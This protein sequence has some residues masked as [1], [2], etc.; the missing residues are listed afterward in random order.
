LPARDA[1]GQRF[2]DSWQFSPCLRN[3]SVGAGGAPMGDSCAYIAV[4]CMPGVAAQEIERTP[5]E[6][7]FNPA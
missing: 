6:V 1:G 4:K 3:S 7:N 5:H 2:L